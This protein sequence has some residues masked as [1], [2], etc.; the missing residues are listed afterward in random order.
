MMPIPGLPAE[1]IDHDAPRP[2]EPVPGPTAEYGRYLA[3]QCMHCHGETLAGGEKA[4][5]PMPIANITPH[6]TGIGDWTRD[7]F[8]TLMRDGRRPDGSLVDQDNMNVE[9][10]SRYTDEELDALWAFLRSV[11]PRPYGEQ[12]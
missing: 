5:F 4:F 2:P 12:E 10:T 8:T 6:E 11:P 9:R 3:V 7:D 1:I